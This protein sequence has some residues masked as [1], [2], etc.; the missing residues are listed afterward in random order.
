MRGPLYSRTKQDEA[1]LERLQAENH[2]L[3]DHIQDVER[4]IEHLKR[5]SS[6][7]VRNGADLLDDSQKQKW[8]KERESKR[9]QVKQ[10]EANANNLQRELKHRAKLHASHVA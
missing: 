5:P 8:M 6:A 7:L 10:A 3:L 9:L 2:D 1:L 4:E